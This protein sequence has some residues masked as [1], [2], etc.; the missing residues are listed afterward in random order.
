M[1][2]LFAKNTPKTQLVNNENMLYNLTDYATYCKINYNLNS[3]HSLTLILNENLLGDKIN[4]IGFKQIIKVKI[5]DGNYDYFVINSI[6]K[7]LNE[8][9][10]IAIH[11]VTEIVSNLFIIDSRPRN[12]NGVNLMHHLKEQTEEYKNRKTEAIDLEVN[13]DIDKLMSLNAYH[14][15]FHDKIAQIQEEYGFEV[16]KRQF[17]IALLKKVGRTQNPIYNIEYGSNLIDFTQSEDFAVVR[18]VLPVGYDGIKGRIQYSDKIS[19]GITLEKEYNIRLRE[20]D[21]EDDEGYVYYDTLEEC[22]IALND[23]ARQEFTINKIDEP[24]LT[25]DIK[26][27]D[28]GHYLYTGVDTPTHIEVGDVVNCAIPKYSLDINVRVHELNFNVLSKKIEDIVLSNNS[29]ELL[30]V[31][32]LSNVEKEVGKLPS[33][34]EV[35]NIVHVE[36]TNMMNAG[37]ENSHVVVKK[38]EVLVMDSP[39]KETAQNIWRWNKAGLMHS[40]TG[41][42]GIYTM[43]MRQDGVKAY[44]PLI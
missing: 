15:S 42:D 30:K 27:A 29:T 38:D 17:E 19:Q 12:L 40:T 41:Y 43:G 22:K 8:L 24:L 44:C 31:P 6:N 13:S 23:L 2:R 1:I 10:I 4:E 20:P 9:E 11:W 39:D 14:I 16:R 36:S 34:D 5:L 33:R 18:G 28:L 3:N 37:L 26:Y 7:K 32:T 21:T 35:Y 25:F